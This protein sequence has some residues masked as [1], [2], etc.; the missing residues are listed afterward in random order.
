MKASVYAMRRRAAHACRSTCSSDAASM[1]YTRP[2]RST[3]T[4]HFKW[5]A[6]LAFTICSFHCWVQFTADHYAAMHNVRKEAAK[7]T[8]A[9]P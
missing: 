8:Q 2:D 1:L 9:T 3:S 7:V 6:G 5:T 4:G